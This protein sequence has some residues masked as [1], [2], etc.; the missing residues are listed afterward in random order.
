MKMKTILSIVTLSG[1]LFGQSLQAQEI[2]SYSHRQPFLMQPILRAFTPETR[3]EIKVLYSNMGLAQCPKNDGRNSAADVVL[4]VDVARLTAYKSMDLLAKNTFETL[5]NNIPF[6][7][8]SIDNTLFALSKRSRTIAISKNR[9]IQGEFTRIKV[10][11]DPQ[12]K[13][14]VCTSPDNYV[15]NFALMASLIA[16][17]GT[18]AAEEWVKRLSANS[19]PKFQ[20]IDRAQVKGIFE[21]VCDVALVES[22]CYGQMKFSEHSNQKKDGLNL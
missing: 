14:R 22:Y 4:A 19:A 1:L 16:H 15:Y 20:G 3:I 12:W 5:K 10:L 13:G 18:E 11:V 6:H 2:N 21:R 7:R 8:S 17:H 9:V